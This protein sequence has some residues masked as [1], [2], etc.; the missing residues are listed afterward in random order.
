MQYNQWKN[1][2]GQGAE[3][4]YKCLT[5]SQVLL[6]WLIPECGLSEYAVSDCCCSWFF[7]VGHTWMCFQICQVVSMNKNSIL[8]CCRIP[9]LMRHLYCSSQE[10][11]STIF[12]IYVLCNFSFLH[13][14]ILKMY[15]N[16]LILWYINFTMDIRVDIFLVSIG[17]YS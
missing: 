4:M 9:P 2:R 3:S 6:P 11:V 12:Y 13:F 10:C 1:G 7:V 15:N 17:R 8:L 5:A 16:L 14:Y